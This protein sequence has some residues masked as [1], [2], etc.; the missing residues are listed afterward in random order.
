MAKKR[1]IV[2]DNVKMARI[3]ISILFMLVK[4][5]MINGDNVDY[6]K[7][8]VSMFISNKALFINNVLKFLEDQ[9]YPKSR[10]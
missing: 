2:T 9:E 4:V 5:M 8:M 7:I 1:K 10:M 6:P 3:R